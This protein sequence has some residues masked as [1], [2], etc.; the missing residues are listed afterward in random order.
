M[1]AAL[2][3]HWLADRPAPGRAARLPDVDDGP[4][5]G[6][7]Y[8]LRGHAVV[9]CAAA[10]DGVWCVGAAGDVVVCT[11]QLAEAAVLPRSGVADPATCV[12]G[13]RSQA[14]VGHLTGA[15]RAYHVRS[16]A[17]LATLRHH[18]AAIAALRM[19]TA[20]AFSASQDCTVCQW[21]VKDFVLVREFLGHSATVRCLLV[22]GRLLYSGSD[23]GTV[24]LWSVE[25]GCCTR[26]L[27]LRR[28]VW[29]LV[30]DCRDR[31]WSVAKGGSVSVW[32]ELSLRALQTL[33]EPLVSCAVRV[34]GAMWL[35]SAVD[36]TVTEWDVAA[37]RPCGQYRVSEQP[38]V[39][40]RG[41]SVSRPGLVLAVTADGAVHAVH[42]PPAPGDPTDPEEG[43]GSP[44]SL[45]AGPALL[46]RKASPWGPEARALAEAIQELV[47]EVHTL[48]E[49]NHVLAA[50][51]SLYPLAPNNVIKGPSA[52]DDEAIGAGAL[53]PGGTLWATSPGCPETCSAPALLDA[54]QLAEATVQQRDFELQTAHCV[55]QQ[56]QRQHARL[57]RVQAALLHRCAALEALLPGPLPHPAPARII[58]GTASARSPAAVQAPNQPQRPLHTD[59]LPSDRALAGPWLGSQGAG[60]LGSTGMA[61]SPKAH[62]HS[63]GSTLL[64]PPRPRQFAAKEANESEETIGPLLQRLQVLRQ[65]FSSLHAHRLELEVQDEYSTHDIDHY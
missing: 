61:T 37:D 64:T 44:L 26:K 50:T 19:T 28:P 57:E 20:M 5:A 15:I 16:R 32:Q 55:V 56:L 45:L 60:G 46:P 9:D 1:D 22:H 49:T 21:A 59:T 40:L 51:L 34:G 52:I 54:L 10:G 39:H 17:R 36:G 62:K 6:P 12:V 29:D 42:R 53:V 14:W 35:G 33:S 2:S 3:A 58:Q 41:R 23:D 8:T 4:R 11:S 43:D 48:I 18:T 7:V 63:D 24:R 38:L 47:H 31:L 65:E 30:V 13:R 27:D 25:K